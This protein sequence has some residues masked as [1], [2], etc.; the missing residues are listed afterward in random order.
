MEKVALGVAIGS[1]RFIREGRWVEEIG[2]RYRIPIHIECLNL[3]WVL[4]LNVERGRHRNVRAPEVAGA[5][6]PQGQSLSLAECNGEAALESR[7]AAELPAG[8][9]LAQER[10]AGDSRKDRN[11]INI[12]G[13]E[14][15]TRIEIGVSI[16]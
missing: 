11:L 6:A 2:T 15:M 10:L 4:L 3:P 13:D 16:V 12:G 9:C 14:A 7:H 8:D 5:I 1:K